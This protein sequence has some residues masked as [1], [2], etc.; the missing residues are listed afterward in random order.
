MAENLRGTERNTDISPCYREQEKTRIVAAL[1]AASSLLVVGASGC[2]KTTLAKFVCEELKQLNL[3][4]AF[5]SPSTAKVMMQEIAA[6][7]NINTEQTSGAMQNAI[8]ERLKEEICFLIVDDA[9]RLQVGLRVWL[10]NLLRDG[11]QILLFAVHPPPKDVF[12]KLPRIE[13]KDLKNSQIRELM[14]TAANELGASVS[15]G[16]LAELQS[17]VGGNPMLARRVIREEFL[18]LDD[19]APDHQKWIDGTPLVMAGLLC[20]AFIRVLARGLQMR[21]LWMFGMIISIALG[22]TRLLMRSLPRQSNKLGG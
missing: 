16:Q 1:R 17:R 14:Q 2:G 18:G 13:L 22:I 4:F 19:T 7:L 20:F 9:H 21:D 11:H 15:R 8:T 6:Q 5:A 12:L 3:S 10:E